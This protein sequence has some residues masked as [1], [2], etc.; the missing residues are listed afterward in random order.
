MI[1]ELSLE[2][3]KDA[4]CLFIQWVVEY[5][6]GAFPGMKSPLNIYG[7]LTV[8]LDYD[9]NWAGSRSIDSITMQTVNCLGGKK[10]QSCP[11]EIE[12]TLESIKRGKRKQ[13][14]DRPA[15]PMLFGD[16]G[17]RLELLLI[18]NE[19]LRLDAGDCGKWASFRCNQN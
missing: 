3:H 6:L 18:M 17:M 14:R 7:M 19:S 15:T 8:L 10:K 5:L 13:V 1:A 9:Q 16:A 4:R 11:G 2:S 12:Q